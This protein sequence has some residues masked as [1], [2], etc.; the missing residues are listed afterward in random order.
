MTRRIVRSL[1]TSVALGCLAFLVM[2]A[3]FLDFFVTPPTIRAALLLATGALG[4]MLGT[5]L[6]LDRRT[7]V[8]LIGLALFVALNVAIWTVDWNSRKPFVR[9]LYQ[10]RPG[11][12]MAQVDSIMSRYMRSP[13][14]PGTTA[15]NLVVG[16]RHTTAAWGNS[17]VGLISYD[18]NGY[19]STITF[20]PD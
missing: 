1:I 17:D 12:T 7:R 18:A 8:T 13:A 6:Y 16:Y 20:L 9:D 14:T 19:V 15:D 5:L 10:I 11:M 4:V 3:L 2:V